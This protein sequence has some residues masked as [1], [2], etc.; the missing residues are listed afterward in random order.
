MS[1]KNRQHNGREKK[2]KRTN[3][4]I[5]N[6]PGTHK[7]KYRVIPTPLWPW[8]ELTTLVVLGPDYM[9]CK[10][11]YDHDNEGPYCIVKTNYN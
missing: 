5:Q 7:S 6:V 4:E 3:N 9:G 1:E 11:N 10:C 8:F 2:Y